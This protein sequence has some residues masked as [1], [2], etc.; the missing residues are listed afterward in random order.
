MQKVR[1]LSIADARN[2]PQISCPAV[3]STFLDNALLQR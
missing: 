2:V 1:S 3:V